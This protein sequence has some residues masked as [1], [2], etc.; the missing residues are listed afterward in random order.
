MGTLTRYEADWKLVDDFISD[1]QEEG[2]MVNGTR[3]VPNTLFENIDWH[4][5]DQLKEKLQT[6]KDVENFDTLNRIDSKG[7]KIN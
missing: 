7:K 3:N 1:L 4:T 6:I 5:L 2:V